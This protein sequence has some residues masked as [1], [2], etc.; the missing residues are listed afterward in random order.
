MLRRRWKK[1]KKGGVSMCAPLRTHT[2]HLFVVIFE[3]NYTIRSDA[4]RAAKVQEI[5][6]YCLKNEILVE[7]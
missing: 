7:K 2:E 3:G 4:G 1:T 6:D 5:N